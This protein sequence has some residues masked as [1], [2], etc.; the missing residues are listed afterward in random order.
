MIEH[1]T[2]A[3]FTVLNTALDERS[4][5]TAY[6]NLTYGRFEIDR[7]FNPGSEEYE[8]GE[9]WSTLF[10][11][12]DYSAN[13]TSEFFV[14]DGMLFMSF[15]I[16]EFS[17]TLL[18]LKGGKYVIASA[19]VE[20]GVGASVEIIDYSAPYSEFSELKE[21]IELNAGYLPGAAFM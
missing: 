10:E 13:H 18:A 19:D 4:H 11:C 12:D 16:A 5:L 15:Q 6:Y 1:E 14:V 21:F 3:V 9:L 2:S 7:E 17:Y 20:S 8:A